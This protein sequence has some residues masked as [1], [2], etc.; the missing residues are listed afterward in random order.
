MATADYLNEIWRIINLLIS[1]DLHIKNFMLI[2]WL[3]ALGI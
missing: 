3:T 1:T 2:D